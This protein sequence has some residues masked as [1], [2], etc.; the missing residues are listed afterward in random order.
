MNGWMSV[1]KVAWWKVPLAMRFYLLIDLSTHKMGGT[2][3]G[4]H[5]LQFRVVEVFIS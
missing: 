1:C 3:F 4:Y 5:L 2:Q